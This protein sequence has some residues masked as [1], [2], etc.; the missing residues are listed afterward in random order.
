MY[1]QIA[2]QKIFAMFYLF[3]FH[4]ECRNISLVHFGQWLSSGELD[5]IEMKSQSINT[6]DF[7]MRSTSRNTTETINFEA[8][9]T[10][11]WT[12]RELSLEL[13]QMNKNRV[14]DCDLNRLWHF[15]I[16]MAKTG[17]PLLTTI[18]EEIL[19]TFSFCW[20]SYY[21]CRD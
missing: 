9:H 15:L 6:S 7:L 19:V 20:H 11:A 4:T 12:E 16:S 8:P 14:R 18:T 21:S 10:P 5:T 3:V 17:E 1:E 2:N 13:V